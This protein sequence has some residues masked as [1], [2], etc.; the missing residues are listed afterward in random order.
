[1][2]LTN[3]VSED[4]NMPRDQSKNELINHLNNI[5]LNLHQQIKEIDN[6][7]KSFGK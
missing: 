5:K 1:M 3:I 2:L 6:I 4:K 7:I